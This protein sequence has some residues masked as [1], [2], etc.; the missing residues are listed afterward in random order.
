M[1]KS[2]TVRSSERRVMWLK[3]T[4]MMPG[5]AAVLGGSQLRI[6]NRFVLIAVGSH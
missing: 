5:E 4:K 6:M 2:D 3:K 1:R